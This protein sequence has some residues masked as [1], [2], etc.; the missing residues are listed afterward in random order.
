[1]KCSAKQDDESSPYP[2]YCPNLA[3]WP[4]VGWTLWML[5]GEKEKL[6]H[7]MCE[8]LQCFSREVYA[9]GTEHLP[10]TWKKW[11]DKEADFAEKNIYF[12]KNVTHDICKS[13]YKCNYS[14]WLK[15]RKQ[16][17]RTYP[18]QQKDTVTYISF[19]NSVSLLYKLMTP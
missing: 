11:D 3:P 5:S 15:N 6:K 16:Y 7:I 12:V 18:C 14:L 2:P 13:D 1:M 9:T 10:Q 19:P 8:Q 17:F 4:L